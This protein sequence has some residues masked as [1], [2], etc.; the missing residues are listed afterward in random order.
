VCVCVC[1]EPLRLAYQK[2]HEAEAKTDPLIAVDNQMCAGL[3]L[4]LEGQSLRM[5]VL[6]LSQLAVSCCALCMAVVYC[7]VLSRVRTLNFC[8]VHTIQNDRTLPPCSPARSHLAHPHAPTLLTRTLG[9]H[10]LVFVVGC[11]RQ[12]HHTALTSGWSTA[13]FLS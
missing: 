12:A 11:A 10:D 3:L 7:A 8:G 6:N 1:C 2:Q 9:R 13:R 4:D 5:C